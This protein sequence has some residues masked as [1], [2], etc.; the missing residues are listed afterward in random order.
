MGTLEKT[1]EGDECF[2][3]EKHHED[4]VQIEYR[5]KHLQMIGAPNVRIPKIKTMSVDH[6]NELIPKDCFRNLTPFDKQ[7]EETGNEGTILTLSYRH[8]ALVVY[9]L[10][11]I[12]NILIQEE[13]RSDEVKR[14]FIDECKKFESSGGDDDTKKKLLKWGEMFIPT[15]PWRREYISQKLLSA[16]VSLNDLPLLQKYLENHIFGDESIDAI[17]KL[18]DKFGWNTLSTQL[19]AAFKKLDREAA[20][21]VIDSIIGNPVD[22][23]GKDEKRNVCLTLIGLLP[24][25]NADNYQNPKAGFLYKFCVLAERV[26]YDP[27]NHLKAERVEM[28]VPVLVKLAY[29]TKNVLGKFWTGVAQHFLNKMNTLDTSTNQTPVWIRNETISCSCEDCVMLSAFMKKNVKATEFK[30]VKKRRVHLEKIVSGVA[31]LTFITESSGRPPKM[32]V[33]KTEPT[34]Y[35]ASEEQIVARKLMS[36]LTSILQ[37]E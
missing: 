27:L 17:V 34:S 7:K 33:S 19:M 4:D 24:T 32:V 29:Q 11:N 1:W 37:K 14:I 25:L 21:K 35:T 16:I 2:L 36:K 23:V 28:M 9:P 30:I 18:C 3:R 10:E 5:L 6:V 13:G 8:S 22:F 12:F 15:T 20:L 26:N 31:K